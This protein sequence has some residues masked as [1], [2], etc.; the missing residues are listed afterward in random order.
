MLGVAMQALAGGVV[1][2]IAG[3]FSGEMHSL[4]F[5]TISLRSWLALA[6]LVF[7]GSVVGFTSYLYMLKN[8]TAARVGTYALVNPVV[9]LLLGWLF[10]SEPISLR[11]LLAAAII[12]SS[13]LLV[14]TAP[15]KQPE[16][17]LVPA[18]G[19]AD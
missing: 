2:W 4:H 15:A 11:T 8:T 6:Y 16:G 9:A 13:V 5:A 17:S 18:G 1:L 19:E 10:A 3:F 7:F 14:I 12:L